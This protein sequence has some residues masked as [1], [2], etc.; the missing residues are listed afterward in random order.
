MSQI[1]YACVATSFFF[2][3][4]PHFVKGP[5]VARY[6]KEHEVKTGEKLDMANDPRGATAKAAA[7]NPLINRAAACHQ[8]Q[9]E[10]LPWFFG[11]LLFGLLGKVPHLN[12]DAVA[13]TYTVAR[14]VFIVAYL[15]GTKPWIGA[16]RSITWIF[17]M[18][19]CAYLFIHAAALG[20]APHYMH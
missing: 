18:V 13:L 3:Y 9:L 8:N 2:A 20:H 7:A 16:V 17:C 19:S 4:V 11:A 10:C 15:F 12:I 5:L 6:V 1:T 14:A